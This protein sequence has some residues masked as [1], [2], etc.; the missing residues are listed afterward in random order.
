MATVVST[1]YPPVVS[2]FQNAFVNTEDAVVYFTLS[3][4]NSASEIKHV[5]VSC[6]NQL[7]NENA[8]N[9]LS[10]ILIEDLQFDKVSGMYYVTIP[11]AYIEGNAFN[12]MM[13]QRRIVI[14]YH[15]RN[16]FQNGL[17]FV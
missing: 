10:G 4:F 9:K 12:T 11:T 1:L 3:S 13:K 2:T 14:F 17:L 6:V 5:H 8:L 15:I 7:N 16:I